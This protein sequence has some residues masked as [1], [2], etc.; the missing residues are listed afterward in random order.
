MPDTP[1]KLVIRNIGLFL[2]GRIE[3][4]V[5]DADC[6]IAI[7]GRIA[8]WGKAAEMDTSGATVEI[9]AQG[10]ALCPG[11][12]DSHVHPVVGDYTPRQQQ[13]NWIELDP[14][15]RRHNA[16][17]RRRGAHARTPEGHRGAQGDG[18]RLA[19]LVREFPPLRG[20]GACRRARH[21]AW[22]RR[23][24]LQGAG[25]GGG[26][27]PGRGRAGVGQGRQDGRADGVVGAKVRHP[28]DDPHRRAVDPRLGPDRRRHG[29]G[30]RHG[31]RGPHQ[32]RPFRPARRPDPVPVRKLHRRARD[33][34][35]RQ[36]ACRG[37]HAQHGARTRQARSD[38][39]RHRRAGRL[40]G[41]AARHPADDRDALG[42]RQC[43]G[44]GRLL[45]RHRQHRPT[46]R[47]RHRHR[48]GRQG[49]GFRADGPGPARTGQ[50][51]ARV[52]CGLATCPASA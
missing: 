7:D 1:A 45:L 2:S 40:G 29:D 44:R 38:H 19:A 14:A 31:C 15:R 4:P 27:A 30:N 46:A 25:R 18:D 24:R 21:R 20:Q 13:L 34:A 37:A 9:D 33:R 52:R 10:V 42:L 17:F 51:A 5:L 39:P 50:V 49:S 8:G 41:A 36:R 48:R 3:E 23:A 32:R 47:A 28:V 26:Q 22:P 11:L 35:Q 16:D 43:A 12:I 6:L